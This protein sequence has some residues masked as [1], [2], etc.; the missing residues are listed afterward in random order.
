M[1]DFGNCCPSRCVGDVVRHD[2]FETARELSEAAVKW[3]ISLPPPLYIDP[4]TYGIQAADRGEGWPF[5][6]GEPLHTSERPAGII[7][8]ELLCV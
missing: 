7:R 1:R 8:S 5:G 6:V 2:Q 3:E 4:V